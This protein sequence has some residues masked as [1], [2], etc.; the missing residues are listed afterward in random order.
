MS[1][2]ALTVV[3][4]VLACLGACMV[5]VEPIHSLMA[6]HDCPLAMDQASHPIPHGARLGG[7][8]APPPVGSRAR[9]L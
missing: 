9:L 5:K 6:R 8:A 1:L 3:A 2:A 7:T 4:P